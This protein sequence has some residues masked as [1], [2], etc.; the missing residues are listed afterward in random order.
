MSRWD[1]EQAYENL[2][3]SGLATGDVTIRQDRPEMRAA[4]R[5]RMPHDHVAVRVEP[6]FQLLD[7]SASGVAFLSEVP[8]QVNSVLQI[9]VYGTVAFQARVV[10]CPLLETDARLMEVR[11]RVQCRFDSEATGKHL[12]LMLKELAPDARPSGGAAD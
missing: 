5:F 3:Q 12:L 2:L 6:R 11:Y 7:L 1:L 9:I 4:P 8:F 10:S